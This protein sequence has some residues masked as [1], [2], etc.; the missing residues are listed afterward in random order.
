MN[1]TRILVAGIGNIFLGDDAF[2]VEVARRL[3]ARGLPDGVQ[4][5]DFGLRGLDLAYAMLSGEHEV[6]ILVDAAPLDG[7]PGSVYLIEPEL[8][9][10]G[11][12]DGQAVIDS[13]GMDPVKVLRLVRSLGGEPMRMFV[14]GCEPLTLG[15]EEGAMGLS[16][17]VETAVGEAIGLIE[18]LIGKIRAGEPVVGGMSNVI[19]EGA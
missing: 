12:S 3:A 5:V 17:P 8:D 7:S 4:V 18:S 10:D 14:V 11:V 6:A 15:P 19:L 2:G 1:E 9:G 16:A 13:H